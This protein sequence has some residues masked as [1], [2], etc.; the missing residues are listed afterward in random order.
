LKPNQIEHLII[1][2]MNESPVHSGRACAQALAIG[3]TVYTT[4]FKGAS[5]GNNARRQ[6]KVTRILSSSMYEVTLL[7]G[8]VFEIR[9]GLL[10]VG[11]HLD[12]P[13]NKRPRNNGG[14]AGGSG[15]GSGGG[16]GGGAGVAPLSSSITSA[17]M[18]SSHQ[19]RQEIAAIVAQL[20]CTAASTEFL[21]RL[22][23]PTCN[24]LELLA[25]LLGE[26]LDSGIVSTAP[27][28]AQRVGFLRAVLAQHQQ[29]VQPTAAGNGLPLVNIDLSV[30]TGTARRELSDM[31]SH[32][33]VY[34]AAVGHFM[35][36]LWNPLTSTLQLL[37][38]VMADVI[39]AGVL[40]QQQ[41]A[42]VSLHH[43]LLSNVA[44]APQQQQQQQE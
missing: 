37:L 39:A 44:P 12:E 7:T 24:T 31:L 11:P 6:G 22:Y 29:P 27:R 38:A 19:L 15:G 13:A 10:S 25:A 5:G 3:T 28:H 23:D 41:A 9:R 21:A 35:M 4:I 1:V 43:T 30:S 17:I 26:V 33:V 8:E 42:R 14:N 32:E 20:P 34:T 36:R 18:M 16:D 2:V 40:T